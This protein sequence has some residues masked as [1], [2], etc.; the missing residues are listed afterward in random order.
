MSERFDKG[1]QWKKF[2][3]HIHTPA[4]KEDKIPKNIKPS[5]IIDK[6]ISEGLDAICISDHNSGDWIDEVKE[7]AKGKGITVF[8]GVEITA[9]SGKIN[10]HILAI[11]DPTKSQEDINIFLGKFGIDDVDKRG[12]TDSIAKKSPMRLLISY[13]TVVVFHC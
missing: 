2:D 10:I 13:A 8:P 6:A 11:F 5:D 1:L 7:A 12:N 9:P 4:S 3:L